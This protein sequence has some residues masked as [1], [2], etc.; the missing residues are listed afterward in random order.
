MLLKHKM[1]QMSNPQIFTN[2]QCE[3]P[4]QQLINGIIINQLNHITLKEVNI[5]QLIS[6]W[7]FR[8]NLWLICLS[9]SNKCEVFSIMASLCQLVI[10]NSPL[11]Y[12]LMSSVQVALY[13]ASWTQLCDLAQ[14]LIE[15]AE[16]F[17]SQWYHYTPINHKMISQD[18]LC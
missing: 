6:C 13:H 9:V 2:S 12:V 7:I 1:T 14:V 17:V 15:M 5:L 4:N 8:N 18:N 16:V 10:Q 11:Q 3:Q